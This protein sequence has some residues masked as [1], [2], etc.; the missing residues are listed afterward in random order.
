M[1]LNYSGP[2]GSPLRLL[3][4]VLVRYVHTLEPLVGILDRAL[5]RRLVPHKVLG[6]EPGGVDLYTMFYGLRFCE[7]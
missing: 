6:I 3:R 1:P 4:P 2:L 5:N 7:G